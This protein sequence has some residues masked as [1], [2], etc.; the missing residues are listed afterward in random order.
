MPKRRDRPTIGSTRCTTRC[1]DATSW[2][3]PTCAAVPTTAHRGSTAR[4]SRTSRRTAWTGGWTNWRTNSGSERIDP[5][6]CDACT[7]P[8][9][10]A[11]NGRW[12]F[13]T[14]RDRVV[15]MAVVLVLEPIFEADLEPEQ[16]AYRPET[17][18]PGRR[19]AGPAA[20]QDGAYGGG[21]RRLVRL[22]RQHP[23]RRA[24]EVAVPAH[25]RSAPPG[26][27][28]DVAGGTGG[29]D[30]RAGAIA[31][32][33]PGTRTRDGA[34][35]KGLRSRRCWRTSTCVASSW[36]GR[37]WG[38]SSVSSAQIVNY[39]DDFV[40][41]CRGTADEAMTA[42]RAMMSKLKLTVNETKTRL[43]RVP[44]ETFDFLGYTIGRCYSPRTGESYIG[45]R[46]SA[47]KIAAALPDEISELTDRRWAWRRGRGPGRPS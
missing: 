9:R 17:Q 39:A 34:A 32:G 31:I 4:R 6:R 35:R 23:A 47:K 13:R 11:S 8:N 40:I 25:Q 27:D 21:R 2:S 46:P 43:C 26:A 16:Y 10:M 22:L 12:G 24:D 33:R 19:Q 41:C 37:R 5:N 30:R 15:Q 3:A 29:R 36:A 28:Q 44:E 20:G 1:T 18:C 7:S 45:T 42:M 14:I 38:T